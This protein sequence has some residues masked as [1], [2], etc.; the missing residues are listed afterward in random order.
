VSERVIAS[1]KNA[2]NCIKIDSYTVTQYLFKLYTPRTYSAQ[3]S[4]RE[5]R[6]EK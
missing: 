1:E 2:V 3:H 5:K 4:E 6:I